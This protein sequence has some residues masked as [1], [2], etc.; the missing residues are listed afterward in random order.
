VPAHGVASLFGQQTRELILFDSDMMMVIHHVI[1]MFLSGFIWWGMSGFCDG[2]MVCD[3]HDMIGLN[4]MSVAALEAGGLGCCI[5]NMFETK[6]G[7]FWVLTM[8]H[9]LCLGAGWYCM[10]MDPSIKFFYVTFVLSIPLIY[11]RQKYM[12]KEVANGA[13][14]GAFERDRFEGNNGA[15]KKK[16]GGG[17]GGGGEGKKQKKTK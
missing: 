12:L 6:R 7:F 4:G 17:G 1:T 5:W 3:R 11:S 2:P 9:V 8:S 13:P 16:E 10:F 14:S 15:G